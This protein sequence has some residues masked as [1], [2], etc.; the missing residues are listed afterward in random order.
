LGLALRR[1][2]LRLW[3]LWLGR[4]LWRSSIGR[5]AH[6]VQASLDASNQPVRA[7][8]ELHKAAPMFVQLVIVPLKLGHRRYHAAHQQ[9]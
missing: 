7:L 8:E 1:W 6:L 3:L 5:P 9:G 4:L 2:R